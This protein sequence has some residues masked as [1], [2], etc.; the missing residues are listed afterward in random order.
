MGINCCT[1]SF[2]NWRL[3]ATRGQNH[4]YPKK[5]QNF[6]TPTFYCYFSAVSLKRS[7]N[8]QNGQFS[9]LFLSFKHC[10]CISVFYA[11]NDRSALVCAQ[12]NKWVVCYHY[13]L[14][15]ATRAHFCTN[16]LW[17]LF[18]SLFQ[19]LYFFLEFVHGLTGKYS[20]LLPWVFFSVFSKWERALATV[21]YFTSDAIYYRTYEWLKFSFFFS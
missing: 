1:D 17:F 5:D 3:H 13:Q 4:Y 12:N 10:V 7:A 15:M 20:F 18:F 9:L 21:Q 19:F 16:W 2:S 6:K 8:K 11:A 14:T